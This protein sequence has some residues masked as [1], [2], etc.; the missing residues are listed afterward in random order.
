MAVRDLVVATERFRARQGRELLAVSA[1]DMIAL[2]TLHVDG[3]QTISALARVLGMTPASAT[4][5]A[6]RLERAGLVERRPHPTDRRKR[7]LHPTPAAT[8]TLTGIY[9]QMGELAR[10]AVAGLPRA[11]VLS[12]LTD[13]ASSLR[14]APAASGGKGAR[15]KRTTAKQ[16]STARPAN[17]PSR[18]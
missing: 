5:L 7:L 14:S 10:P 2:G 6:D 13:A 9:E 8:T 3:P 11:A 12:F 4:E 1:T 15:R 17:A 18:R 16:T